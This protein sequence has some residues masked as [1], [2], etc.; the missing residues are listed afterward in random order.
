MI[1]NGPNTV[2]RA[3]FQ[4]PSSVSFLALTE[5]RGQNSVS[6]SHP[7]SY[8]PKKSQLTECSAKR[9][10]FAAELSEFSLPKQY[11][12]KQYPAR[13]L[14]KMSRECV[15]DRVAT[16]LKERAVLKLPPV[17]R[18]SGVVMSL[19]AQQECAIPHH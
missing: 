2:R 9:T 12:R 16:A 6:S 4:T 5:L 1:R 8:V 19:K 13:F 10:E 15:M 11:S 3:R 18:R 17:A 7:I 14:N